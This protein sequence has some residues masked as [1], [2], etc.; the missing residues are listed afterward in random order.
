MIAGERDEQPFVGVLEVCLDGDPSWPSIVRVFKDRDRYRVEDMEGRVL[1]IRNPEH[2][3]VFLDDHEADCPDR[4]APQRYD[5]TDGE[6]VR[7]GAHAHVIER[8]EPSDWRG[9]DFATPTGEATAT[10]YLGR[11]AWQVELAPPEHKQWALTVT[12]DAVTG[13]TYEQRT[14]AH[15]VLTRWTD[16]AVV[17]SHPGELFTWDGDARWFAVE[18]REVSMEEEREDDRQRAA[19]MAE[20]GVGSLRVSST[21]RLYPHEQGDDDGFFASF[22]TRAHGFVA[23]RPRSDEPWHLDVH[24]DHTERWSDAAW[25]WCIGSEDSP[26]QLVE[27]RRQL[28]EQ[29]PAER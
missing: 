26:E 23:R 13:M 24:Y 2:T 9:D 27:I 3:F 4:G 29:R 12:V 16:L 25:D 7:P 22:S 6:W 5:N 8:R 19:W 21:V 28:S 20:R 18:S 11:D 14:S 10:T 1:T 17:E 15:G